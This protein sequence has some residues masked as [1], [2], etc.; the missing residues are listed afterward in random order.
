MTHQ[1]NS[2]LGQDMPQRMQ[3]SHTDSMCNSTRN[4]AIDLG[5]HVCM[6]DVSRMCS[7]TLLLH[8]NYWMGRFALWAR[9]SSVLAN[10]CGIFSSSTFGTMLYALPISKRWAL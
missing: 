1:K 8:R 2:A 3:C 9:G 6:N 10:Q 7:K 4:S 5:A